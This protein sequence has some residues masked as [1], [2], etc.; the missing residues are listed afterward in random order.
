MIKYVA[1]RNSQNMTDC[2]VFAG[3]WRGAKRSGEGEVDMGSL[4]NA[5]D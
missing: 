1:T 5:D 4:E 2:T 3:V